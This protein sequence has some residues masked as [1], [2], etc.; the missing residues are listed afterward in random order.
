MDHRCEV[1]GNVYDKA[2]QVV[3]QGASH[4]FDSFECAIQALAPRIGAYVASAW[5]MLVP[6]NLAIRGHFDE[7]VRDVVMS[8]AAFT[9]ARALEVPATARVLTNAPSRITSVT[10]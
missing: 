2:F 9:L 8:V 6:L 1:C 7:A 10:A 5:L 4:T 3:M